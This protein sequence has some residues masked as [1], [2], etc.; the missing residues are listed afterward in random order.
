LSTLL[1]DA[2]QCAFV[3]ENDVVEKHA[4]SHVVHVA[5]FRNS[6]PIMIRADEA[7]CDSVEL[8]DLRRSYF[9]LRARVLLPAPCHGTFWERRPVGPTK[10]GVWS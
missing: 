7:D 6:L 4:T 9:F 5:C 2:G 8:T 3:G 10:H 1:P